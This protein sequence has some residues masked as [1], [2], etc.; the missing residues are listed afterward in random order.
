MGKSPRRSGLLYGEL[1]DGTI[2]D[3][4]ICEFDHEEMSP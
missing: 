3:R 2:V 1:I 4:M